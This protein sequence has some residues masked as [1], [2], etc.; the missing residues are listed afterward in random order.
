MKKLF[1]ILISVPFVSIGQES[2]SIEILRASSEEC[3]SVFVNSV[4][5]FYKEADSLCAVDYSRKMNDWLNSSEYDNYEEYQKN[6]TEEEV[7]FAIISNVP[8]FL[9]CY[10]EDQAEARDC[11]QEKINKHIRKNFRY[12]EIAQ[13]M[14]IQGRVYINFIISE[15]GYI[16]NIRTRG[17]DENLKKEAVRII[18]LLPRMLPGTMDDG[19]PV[20]V[21]FSIPITWRLE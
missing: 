18:S 16:E 9:Q 2:I 10:L 17:P 7:K 11:F 4:N 19:T 13:E 15:C 3:K 14:G 1:L 21:P 20:D 6:T 12:P 5:S 8:R